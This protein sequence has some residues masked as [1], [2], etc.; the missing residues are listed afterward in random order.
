MKAPISAI[1]AAV[2]SSRM[3]P[4]SIDLTPASSELLMDGEVWQCVRT[5]LP[6]A[7]ASYT[8]AAISSTVNWMLSSSSIWDMTPPEAIILIWVAPRRSWRRAAARTASTPSQISN[9]ARTPG[10]D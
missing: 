4:C 9:A 1:R 5:Y 3:L 10:T 8:A 7:L 6:V 2:G